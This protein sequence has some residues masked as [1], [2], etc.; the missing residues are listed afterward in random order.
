M[1]DPNRHTQI[2]ASWD[3]GAA[4]AFIETLFQQTEDAYAGYWPPHPDDEEPL[5]GDHHLDL[6]L[7]GAGVVWA[8][9]ELASHGYGK[10]RNDY[11]DALEQHR[12]AT[13]ARISSAIPFPNKDEYAHGLLLGELGFVL[14][15]M[16]L[17][18]AEHYHEIAIDLIGRNLRNSVLEFM[19]G[20]P[21][22]ML[23]LQSLLAS[24]TVPDH[25]ENLL[26]EGTDFLKGELR[27]SASRG[28]QLWAQ[29]LYG[30]SVQILGAVHGFAGNAL[31]ILKSLPFLPDSDAAF[32]AELIRD[33]AKSSAD[34]DG[35]HSN[36]Q[37]TLD[38]HR[39]GRS[40]W[41]V[42]IC[43]GAPGM[44][45]CLSGLIGE[46]D[47]FDNLMISAGN[48]TWDAGPVSKG[49]GLCHGTAGNGWAFLK[50]FEATGDE[51]WMDRARTFAAVALLQSERRALEHGDRRYSLWTGDHGIALFLDA[52][53]SGRLSLPTMERF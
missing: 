11:V 1:F 14:P 31:A 4:R 23:F 10:L 49:G 34:S 25:H 13:A 50:L 5:H 22:S 27:Q 48:L 20:S 51:I 21:G 8:Q 16:R 6:Y 43:H 7:G 52:C 37:Q 3:A 46:D 32:W 9:V 17:A 24:R 33:T 15:L 2:E 44:I 29:N 12:L 19:W 26:R 30:N 38:S 42:Q 18:P 39:D 53:L 41:L 35:D 28:C 36:W 45:A 40:G 47:E